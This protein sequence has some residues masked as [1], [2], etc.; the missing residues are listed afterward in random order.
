MQ[1][2]KTFILNGALMGS[3]G[4][5]LRTATLIF[6]A[7]ISAEIGAEGVG[8]NTIIMSV[9]AFALTLASSGINLTVTRLVASHIGAGRDD[10]IRGTLVGA[11]IYASIFSVLATALLFL[12][13]GVIST[14]VINDT[15]AMPALNIL[16]LS[17]IPASLG[18][19][20]NGYFLARRMAVLN[21]V[22]MLSGQVARIASTVILLTEF[23]SDSGTAVIALAL[24]I[25]ISEVLCFLIAL[26]AFPIIKMRESRE[27]SRVSIRPI[28]EMALPLAASAY[29]RSGLLSLEH[30][31][32][33]KR[34]KERGGS[35]AEA[36]GNLGT[37]QGMALPLILYPMTP[38]SS[39]SGLL[40]PEFAEAEASNDA[41]KRA[42]IAVSAITNTLRY[43]IITA[44]IL[45][46]FS[47]ELGYGIY[48]SYGAGYFI[49]ILSPVIPIMYLDHV[50][51]SMLKGIG[52]HVYSMWVNIADS[53]LSVILVWFLIPVFGIEG[54]A[55]VIIAMELFNFTL[56]YIRLKRR[57]NM[58]LGIMNA[59]IIPLISAIIG[60]VSVARV[61]VIGSSFSPWIFT[62]KVV[63]AVSVYVCM[64]ILL[65]T[66][67]NRCKMVVNRKNRINV[68]ER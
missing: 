45:F 36:L 2:R 17:L 20:F 42:R 24:G 19:V 11:V 12:F 35:M 59:V 46:V 23:S 10:N 61:F 62:L 4:I 48:H 58:K 54:Y 30:S 38:L 3:V 37:M 1:G 50:V 33:P 47:E 66:L 57:V 67:Y 9:Y 41:V 8:L 13:S 21:A 44:V 63:F 22:I 14:A 39:V 64:M 25:T 53:L 15:R 7:Y 29:I 40:L 56:S 55:L 6:G 43:A 52:E 60:A 28:A 26:A 34:L 16:A 49:A 5:V 32:I 51:D 68:N 31:L 65:N 27:K 18:G